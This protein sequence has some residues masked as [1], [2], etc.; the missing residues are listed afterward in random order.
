MKKLMSII[1]IV[2]MA[3][4]VLAANDLQAQTR[5][6][7]KDAK[8]EAK[9]L[10]KQDYKTMGLPLYQQLTDYYYK[11]SQQDEEG[12]PLYLSEDNMAVGNSFAAAK[13]EAINVAKVRL[14]GQI[15]TTVL[16]EAKISLGNSTLSA[17]D[18]A[19]ITKALEKSTQLVAQKLNRVLV[20]QEYYKILKNKNYEVHVVL[21]YNTKNVKDMIIKDAKDILQ[22]ELDD[23]K[24]GYENVLQDIVD[25]G[26]NK[27]ASK[28]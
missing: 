8:K 5:Q 22:K 26:V 13:M 25:K 23:F 7:K 4:L 21:L 1:G 9:R 3:I 12:M 24:P 19:S 27:D 28:K 20:A 18:A 17:E 2:S 10:Q 6:Q 15:Q 14:A 16:A 11:M